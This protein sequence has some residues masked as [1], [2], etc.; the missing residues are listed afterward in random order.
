[1]PA[2]NVDARSNLPVSRLGLIGALG[3]LVFTLAWIISTLFQ[4]NYST[5]HEEISGLAADTSDNAWIMVAGFVV[6]GICTLGLGYGLRRV[7]GGASRWQRVGPV[8]VITAG[9]GIFFAGVFRNDCS[10]LTE[11]CQARIEAGDVSG[12]HMLH[13][14]AGIIAFLSFIFAPFFTGWRLR[15]LPDWRDL[16]LASMFLTP[17]LLVLLV[18]FVGEIVSGWSGVVQ[19][20]LVTTAF[21][22][23]AIMGLR[24]YAVGESQSEPTAIATLPEGIEY[25]PSP[26]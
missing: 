20:L 21:A 14:L 16:S 7:L 15:K 8:L 26:G 23:I 19:R 10:G 6:M 11:V 22:W 4:S 2:T 18:L 25:R 1:M 9:V 24:L 13:D 17:L 3:P 12:Q 5:R